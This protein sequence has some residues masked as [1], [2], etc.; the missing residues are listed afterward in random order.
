MYYEDFYFI[1]QFSFKVDFLKPA[2][3]FSTKGFYLF[4]FKYFDVCEISL[5]N[6]CVIFIC[7]FTVS[8]VYCKIDFPVNLLFCA[9]QEY[10]VEDVDG[11][12][13]GS[14][15]APPP[16]PPEHVQQ[17]KGLGLL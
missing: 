14:D 3:K 13:T 6:V 10:V 15:W 11:E 1:F 5:E 12:M 8:V 4:C 16:L 9:F 7:D 2:L 17:L